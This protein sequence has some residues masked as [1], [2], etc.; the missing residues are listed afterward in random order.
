M[1]LAGAAAIA[2]WSEV[3]AAALD[4]HDVWH[5]TEHFPERIGILG[6]LRGRRAAAADPRVPQQRFILYEIENMAVATSAP[7]LDRLNNPTPWSRKIMARCSLNRTLCRVAASH[8]QGVGSRIL[9]IRLSPQPGRGKELQAWLA[10]KALP[11]L[12]R[13][14]G[15]VGAHLLQKDSDTVR[16]RTSEEKL[17]RGGADASADWV[18]LVE[19]YDAQSVHPASMDAL[20]ETQLKV[21]GAASDGVAAGYVLS[22]LVTSGKT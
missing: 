2:I 3:E 17:R 10:E 9:T 13:K 22:H 18:V 11:E 21:H 19:G 16:P 14:K 1:G 20:S 8:G 12:A 5:S 7:Y 4:E 15:I 6:F